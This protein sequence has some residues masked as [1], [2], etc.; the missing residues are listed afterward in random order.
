MELSTYYVIITDIDASR[1]DKQYVKVKRTINDEDVSAWCYVTY[2]MLQ[3]YQ[4]SDLKQGD[5]V[6]VNFV[7]ND[8]DKPILLDKVIGF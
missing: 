3:A 8:L 4:N 1:S 6:I 2:S 7:D 5:Y